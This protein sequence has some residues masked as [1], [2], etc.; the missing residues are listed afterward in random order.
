MTASDRAPADADGQ[1]GVHPAQVLP[2]GATPP[3]SAVPRP[4]ADAPAEPPG[5][6]TEEAARS[7]EL[8]RLRAEVSTLHARLD[9]RH[10]RVSAVGAVRRVTAAVLIA[11]TA[12]GI[13]GSVVGL[14]AA[15]TALN[16]DRWVTTVAPLPQNPQVAA[17]VAEYTT[18]QVFQAI[19]VEQRLRT[20]LPEQAAFVAG[21]VAGQLRGA[22]RS[23]VTNVLQSEQFSRIWV[24]LNRRAHARALE[25]INGTSTVVVGREDRVQIDLL[26]LINQVLRQLSAQ[27]PTL[28]GRQV[29]L[30]D[31]SSG[32]IPDNLR[33]RV[34][35]AL[36]VTLPAN[37]AQFTVY[38][39]GQLWAAQQAVAQAKRDL[40]LGVI[41][42]VVLLVLALVI[43]PVRRRTL[44]QLG[45]WLVAAAVAVTA[46][47][48]AVRA[49]VLQQVPEGVYRDGVAEVMTT[50]F[51]LLRTRGV[52]L[53]VIGAVLA[54]VMYLV[55]PGRVPV[56]LRRQIAAGF[57]AAGRGMRT[58]GRAASAHGPGWIADHLDPLRVGGVVAAAVVALL[59]SSWTSLLVT[60]LVLAAWEVAVTLIARTHRSRSGPPDVAAGAAGVA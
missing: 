57:R 29:S 47:L 35:D 2:G 3:E 37:F 12:F 56:W 59:L 5:D 16:T 48:R 23:T 15:T 26:P 40:V 13:V 39:S 30:P 45:L 17:A 4:G 10:R 58:G 36:G 42:T 1:S 22:V 8:A 41:G 43:S 53:I 46:V 27:L 51:A 18:V 9:T 52:Q 11:V 38:D 7:E 19:D 44:L 24:E 28:F 54:V 60:V 49:Q 21:P 33:A 50:V 25:I 55:G 34:E 6:G 14:W 20:V 32:A 31:L